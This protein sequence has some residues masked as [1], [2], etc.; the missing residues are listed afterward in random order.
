MENHNREKRALE[1]AAINIFV[2]KYNEQ[3]EPSIRLLYQHDK[4]DAILEDSRR[5]KIG[6]EITHLFYDAEEAKMLLGRAEAKVR[7]LASFDILLEELNA[8]IRRKEAKRQGYPPYYPISLLIRNASLHYG[9]AEFECNRI[10]M[11]L[12]PQVFQNIWLLTRDGG[13]EWFLIKLI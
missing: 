1:R 6:V 9:K 11:Y 5:H 2:L 10:R 3:Y 7:T 4:P 12:P 8:L 13:K